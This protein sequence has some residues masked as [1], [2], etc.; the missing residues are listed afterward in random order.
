M[1]IIKKSI[2]KNYALKYSLFVGMI[3]QKAKGK[4]MAINWQLKNGKTLEDCGVS[5]QDCFEVCMVL[6]AVGISQVTPETIP[7]I[8]AR[9]VSLRA[10]SSPLSASDTEYVNNKVTALTSLSVNV[11]DETASQFLRRVNK[12][13]QSLALPKGYKTWQGTTVR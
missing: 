13:N 5:G 12:N 8:V 6:N 3:R 2:A 1:K 4:K 9:W 11:C 7:V 10:N